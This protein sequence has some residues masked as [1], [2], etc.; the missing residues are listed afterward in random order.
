MLLKMEVK[1]GLCTSN[2]CDSGDFREIY[3]LQRRQRNGPI[4]SGDQGGRRG[5]IGRCDGTAALRE[6][7][8]RPWLEGLV[9]GDRCSGDGMTGGIDDEDGD[10]S[11]GSSGADGLIG[12]A[13]DG[14]AQVRIVDAVDGEG[15]AYR[16]P[17]TCRRS[18]LRIPAEGT[19]GGGGLSD[20]L[21][22]C[23][24]A[25][26]VEGDCAR[27]CRPLDRDSQSRGGVVGERRLW[28]PGDDGLL[29]EIELRVEARGLFC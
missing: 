28:G 13:D 18:G 3:S 16:G 25:G 12:P 19:G 29:R 9:N 5:F 1:E 4:E 17:G 10:R 11:K 26:G 6:T 24:G 15:G 21:R 23:E 20:G 27:E 7:W 8:I 14:E 22:V 2:Y